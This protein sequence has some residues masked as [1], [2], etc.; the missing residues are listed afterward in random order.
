[1]NIIADI[2]ITSFFEMQKEAL[3]DQALFILMICA[4]V[5]LVLEISL[6]APG[7]RTWIGSAVVPRAVTIVSLVQISSNQSQELQFAAINRIKSIFDVENG[8]RRV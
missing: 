8:L 4:V 3:F 7:E 2:C 5:S 6:S 1:M